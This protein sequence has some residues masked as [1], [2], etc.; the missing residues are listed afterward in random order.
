[1]PDWLA[2]GKA[3]M[4]PSASLDPFLGLV[5][6][7]GLL[8][9]ERLAR[10]AVA[11]EAREETAARLVAAG[12]LT[13][14]QS[15]L[16]LNGWYRGF[17]VGEKYKILDVIGEG[18][19]G[20][21]YLCEQLVL[22]R[23]VALKQLQ[24][25][26]EAIPGAAERFLREAVAV[27]ALDHPNIARIHDADRSDDGAFIVMEAVDGVNLHQLTAKLGRLP[28]AR[29]AGL[30][31]QA[32]LGLQHAH[33]RGL[34]HRDIKPGNL[35]VDRAGRVKVLDL[36]L[37][38]FFDARRNNDLTGRF[39]SRRA[40]GTAEF[41]SP[42]QALNSSEVDTRADIYS[43]GGTLYFLLLGRF[44]YETGT[45]L[46]KLTRHQTEA[47]DP[48]GPQRPEVPAGL[49]AVLERMVAKRPGDRYPDP[50]AAAAALEPFAEPPRPL[51]AVEHPHP[52]SYNLGLCPPPSEAFVGSGSSA[53][54]A[55]PA[56]PPDHG[57]P[58]T[59]TETI[60]FGDS[61]GLGTPTPRTRPRRRSA[62]AVGILALLAALAGGTVIGV[63]RGEPP[64]PPPVRDSEII[65]PAELAL[66]GAGSTLA[67]PLLAAWLAPGGAYAAT[68]TTRGVRQMTEQVVDFAVTDGP[69]TDEQLASAERVNGP[70][71]H[72]PG[73]DRGRGDLLSR[74]RPAGAVAIDRA[75]A[76][77]DL[78]RQSR[79]LGRAGTPNRK[80]RIETPRP[81]DRGRPPLRRQRHDRAIDRLPESGQRGVRGQSRRDRRTGVADARRR[82]VGRRRA[83]Q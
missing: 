25:G 59:P 53:G 9:P 8:A 7:S 33:E 14:Y 69:L 71:V 50:A 30:I 62:A 66:A 55:P 75:V 76:R 80:P 15:R 28:V 45:A 36:G 82:P 42:E 67:Q 64:V 22:E 29:A 4:Q 23:L 73:R 56:T 12:L 26:S 40:L 44:P 2:P 47:F 52:S 51:T 32:A 13:P 20:R 61:W 6:K 46:E 81:A 79:A 34:V 11:D 74:P 19:M 18:G 78:P 65:T 17:F 48:V 3:R 58:F 70:V 31:R 24:V 16:L 43:L 41:M 57:L 54:R 1:M 77:G 5:A 38:R 39:D 68:G 35:M 63:W 10:F 21:V 37:A 72:V 49:V 27:A 83:G 60:P